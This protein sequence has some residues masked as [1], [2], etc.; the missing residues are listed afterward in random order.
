MHGILFWCRTCRTKACR[1]AAALRA[2]AAFSA[3]LSSLSAVDINPI[4]RMICVNHH[5]KPKLTFGAGN[6]HPQKCWIVF[7]SR[8]IVRLAHQ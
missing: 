4:V 5:S 8:E 1:F 3:T 7:Q 2:S 6:F